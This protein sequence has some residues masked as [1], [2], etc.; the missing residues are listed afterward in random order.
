[1]AKRA[2]L[3]TNVFVYGF[4]FQSSNSARIIGLINKGELE[5]VITQQVLDEVVRYFRNFHGK[6]LADEFRHYLLE[7]CI[8]IQKSG[9]KAEMDKNK[10]KI[11]DKDAEQIAAAQ[12]LQLKLVSYDRDFEAFEEYITPQD[13]VKRLGKESSN[14]KF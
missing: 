5:A 6:R 8:V 13:F 12:H 7:V 1:M 14:T 10:G 9:L 4:E 2:V 11:K 3:D